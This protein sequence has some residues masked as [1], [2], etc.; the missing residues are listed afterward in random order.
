M[1]LP[2]AAGHDPDTGQPGAGKDCSHVL[3]EHTGTC[4]VC[5]VNPTAKKPEPPAPAPKAK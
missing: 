1:P 2:T 3:N 5:G 4:K